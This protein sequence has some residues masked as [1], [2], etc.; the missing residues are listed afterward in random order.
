M[1]F[2]DFLKSDNSQKEDGNASQSGGQS[3]AVSVSFTPLRLSALKDNSVQAIIKV[4][5]ATTESQLISVDLFAKK[6]DLI[7]FDSTCLSKKTEKRLETFAPG[8][9]KEFAVKVFGSHQTKPGTYSLVSVAYLHYQTY[10]K[11]VSKV[12]KSFPLRVA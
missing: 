2:L 1:G 12:Q 11:V 8:E 3:L 5:N 4:R 7:G 10:D 6:G 9:S